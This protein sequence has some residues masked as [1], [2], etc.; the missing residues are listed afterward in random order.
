[1][2]CDKRYG[3]T[4]N[5]LATKVLPSLMPV[6]ISPNLKLDEFSMLVDLLQEMLEHVSRNQRNKLKLEKFSMPSTDKY[7]Y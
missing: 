5:I 4:V 2:M 6:V 7:V 3:L 1:M